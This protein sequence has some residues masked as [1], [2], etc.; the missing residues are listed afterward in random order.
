VFGLRTEFASN[1]LDLRSASAP[2][3]AGAAKYLENTVLFCVLLLGEF[4]R[5]HCA[6]GNDGYTNPSSF[7][8][9]PGNTCAISFWSSP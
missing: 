1:P 2:T 5:P 4:S 6:I 9:T 8:V 7:G 3:I